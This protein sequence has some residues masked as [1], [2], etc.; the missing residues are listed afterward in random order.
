MIYLICDSRLHIEIKFSFNRLFN[1]YVSFLFLK[2]II[3]GLAELCLTLFYKIQ[4]F[5]LINYTLS[6]F[7]FLIDQLIVFCLDLRKYLL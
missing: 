6:H 2:L 3:G 1:F 4:L 7:F 5:V